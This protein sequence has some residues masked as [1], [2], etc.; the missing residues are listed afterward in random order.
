LPKAERIVKSGT[1]KCCRGFRTPKIPLTTPIR[2]YRIEVKA[3]H[4]DILFILQY[5]A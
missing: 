3:V 5:G 2:Y 4:D 1:E